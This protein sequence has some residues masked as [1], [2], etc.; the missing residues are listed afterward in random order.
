MVLLGSASLLLIQLYYPA[1]LYELEGL[2][3][4]LQIFVGVDIVVGPLLT[5]LVYKQGKKNLVFDLLVIA[6]LQATAFTYGAYQ[7]YQARP[8]YIVWTES[9][10]HLVSVSDIKVQD[11]KHQ[12]LLP[13]F[14]KGPQWIGAK[15]ANAEQHKGIVMGELFGGTVGIKYMAE[16]YVPYQGVLAYISQQ[17][18]YERQY[19]TLNTESAELNDILQQAN[20]L[21]DQVWAIKI[22]GKAVSYWAIVDVEQQTV[23]GYVEQNPIIDNS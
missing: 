23:V 6:M 20:L 5:L 14:T 3:S 1:P 7:F 15:A 13:N 8:A 12:E 10:F 21:S 22:N 11:L 18:D 4:V 2:Q 9:Q 17:I 19:Q 16:F